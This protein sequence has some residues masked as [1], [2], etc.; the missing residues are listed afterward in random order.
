MVPITAFY[1]VVNG[2]TSQLAPSNGG[3]DLRA[4]ASP[5]RQQR[6]HARSGA[7]RGSFAEKRVS[8]ADRA[9]R[10]AEGEQHG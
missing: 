9:H 10:R 5:K 6:G 8:L 2:Y 7:Q 4:S 3:R 1:P